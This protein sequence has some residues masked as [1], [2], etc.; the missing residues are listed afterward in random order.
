MVVDDQRAQ[1]LGGGEGL[2]GVRQCKAEREAEAEAA[3]ARAKAEAR[4]K[5]GGSDRVSSD[6]ASLESLDSGDPGA[7]ELVSFGIRGVSV[8]VEV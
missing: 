4:E 3:L 8:D 7:G 2:L 5:D 1:G 6:E